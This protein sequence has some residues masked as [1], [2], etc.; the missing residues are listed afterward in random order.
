MASYDMQ[1]FQ[2][3]R[4]K[5]FSLGLQ[6]QWEFAC[7]LNIHSEN[8]SSGVQQVFLTSD[9]W[10]EEESGLYMWQSLAYDNQYILE[11]SI[12]DESVPILFLSFSTT[13]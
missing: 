10:K 12:E 5:L 7:I 1:T 4:W 2:K 11:S 13:V 3:D 6:E 8:N 9:L